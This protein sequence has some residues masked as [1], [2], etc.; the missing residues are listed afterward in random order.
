MAEAAAAAACRQDCPLPEDRPKVSAPAGQG[1]R[2]PGLSV[3]PPA[4]RLSTGPYDL[5]VTVGRV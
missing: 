5:I 2:R 3:P 4:C 1:R